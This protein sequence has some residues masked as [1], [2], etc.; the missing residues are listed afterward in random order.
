MHCDAQ[1][2]G[3]H[4]YDQG[5]VLSSMPGGVRKKS[6]LISVSVASDVNS[7]VS[8]S[9]VAARS[10]DMDLQRGWLE[11]LHGTREPEQKVGVP[12][13][14]HWWGCVGLAREMHDSGLAREASDRFCFVGDWSK[15][16]DCASTLPVSG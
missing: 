3:R 12:M 11:G 10:L 7:E 9:R 5:E 16:E 4:T 14:E 6:Y 2:C 13:C 15:N 1:V 8:P